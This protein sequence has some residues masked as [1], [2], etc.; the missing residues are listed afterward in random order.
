LLKID[1]ALKVLLR[2]ADELVFLIKINNLSEKKQFLILSRE[3][4][5]KN[6]GAGFCG[7]GYEDFVF[8]I[9]VEKNNLLILDKFLLQSCVKS[10]FL[11]PESIED[12]LKGIDLDQAKSLVTFQLSS[13]PESKKRS[14]MVV[15]DHL[16]I[17]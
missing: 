5:R 4:S 14:L 11:E 12:P 10:I 13:E 2:E 8:L 1:K 15:A 3:P 16:V 9:E 6:R 7:A 17:K